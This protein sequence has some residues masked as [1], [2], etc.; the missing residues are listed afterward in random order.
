MSRASSSCPSTTAPMSPSPPGWA[1][2]RSPPDGSA[3]RT[4][5]VPPRPLDSVV[6]GVGRGRGRVLQLE[7]DVVEVAVVPILAR[8]EGPDDGVTHGM[9][10]GGGVPSR[11]VVAAADAGTGLAHTEMDPVVAPG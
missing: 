10:M 1:T 6:L 9:E 7:G 3:G 11:R 8:F 2:R 5:A 4:R